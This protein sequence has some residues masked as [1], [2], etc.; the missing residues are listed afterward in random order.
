MLD[1]LGTAARAWALHES[2]K[3]IFNAPPPLWWLTGCA[4]L[5]AA[6]VVLPPSPYIF[7]L[8]GTIIAADGAFGGRGL[9]ARTRLEDLALKFDRD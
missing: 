3:L 9:S 8:D 5:V 2:L 7:A 1:A 6:T 4:L